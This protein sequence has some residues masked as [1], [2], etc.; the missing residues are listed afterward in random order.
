MLLTGCLTS[1]CC[2]IT[3]GTVTIQGDRKWVTGLNK[4]QIKEFDSVIDLLEELDREGITGE[5]RVDIYKRY[6][7]FSARQRGVPF[8]GSFELTPLCNFDC[9][10]CYVHLNRDQMQGRSL[11]TTQQW[12]DILDQAID[13]G[14]M[15]A[16]LTGGECLSYPGFREIYLHLRSRGISVVILTNGQLLTEELADLFAQYPPDSIQITVYGSNEDAYEAVTGRRAFE[17]VKRAIQLLKDRNLRTFLTTTPSRYM[18]KD[19]GELLSFLRS[20]GVQYGVGISTIPAR[21]DTGR[22]LSDYAPEADFYVRFHQEQM[23]LNELLSQTQERTSPAWEAIP[24]GFSSPTLLTCSSGQSTFHMN[25][26]GEMFPCIPFHAVNRSVLEYGFENCWS[27]IREQMKN[28]VPPSECMTC[29][30]RPVC[31]ACAAER[32]M[33]ILNGPLDKSVCE[34]C[35]QL[36]KHGIITLPAEQACL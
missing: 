19:V 9:K 5:A 13:A 22:K 3:F 27:W 1:R 4:I 34:K 7:N 30:N 20:T 11:L 23:Q 33:G 17:D 6:L 36:V 31:D 10:M 35:E 15:Y 16:D 25:W 26:K 32:T 18:Q 29:T 14:M 12:I 24:K 2:V 28:Y 8:C 21:D